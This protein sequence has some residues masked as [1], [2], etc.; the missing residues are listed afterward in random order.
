MKLINLYEDV[1]DL[2]KRREQRQKEEEAFS[3]DE[4][5]DN[6][7]NTLELTIEYLKNQ[8]MSELDARKVVMK[9]LSDI[10]MGHDLS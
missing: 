5:L 8:G 7:D 1:V 3:I 6:I 4:V 2:S 9:H 10:V